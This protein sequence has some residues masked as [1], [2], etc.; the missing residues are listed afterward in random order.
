MK[1]IL[2]NTKTNEEIIVQA[3]QYGV[4]L[5]VIFNNDPS[6]QIMFNETEA[7]FV[8]KYLNEKYF[9]DTEIVYLEIAGEIKIDN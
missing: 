2:E 4:G 7:E 1:A 9:P 8:A 3:Q 5:Y 6:E